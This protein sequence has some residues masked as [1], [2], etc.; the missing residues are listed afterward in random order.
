VLRGPVE[1]GQYTS[2]D[3]TQ[4]LDDHELARSL[5]S[6]GDCY[7]NALAESF[8]DSFK[9]ELISD[10]VWR[11]HEQ[12]ELA[13][14]EWVG[15]YNHARLHSSIGD[16]PPVEYEQLHALT[17]AETANQPD[18]SVATS[19]ARAANG[20]TTSRLATVGVDFAAPSPGCL[21]SSAL[22]APSGV[23][24]GRANSSQEPKHGVWPLRSAVEEHAR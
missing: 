19:P 18:G 21:S 23:R 6:T 13:I 14:V 20:L 7:D 12:A 15:W 10:R 8:V 2:D 24:S 17:A 16:I 3:Y 22:V 9:T 11:T 1:P 5:G 4:T